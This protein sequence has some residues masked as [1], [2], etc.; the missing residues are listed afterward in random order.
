MTPSLR[1]LT[2]RVLRRIVNGFAID[3]CKV[4]QW[5][6]SLPDSWTGR[7]ATARLRA[8]DRYSLEGLQ[9]GAEGN[10][11]L[12][13]R[14][15]LPA[16]ARIALVRAD[17]LDFGCG[18]ASYRDLAV[19]FPAT[20]GWTYTGADVNRSIIDSCRK[21]MRENRFEVVPQD[22]TLPF[23]NG[24]FDVIFA[25]GVF[26]CVKQPEKLLA[27]FHRV[28]RGWVLLSRVPVRKHA[29]CGIYL[30]R[31]WHRWGR[32][33]HAIHVFNKEDLDRMC[34]SGGFDVVWRDHLFDRFQLSGEEEPALDQML[35]L[36]KREAA[37]D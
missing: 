30:Q 11:P 33:V 31:V 36:R 12:R 32:E 17:L 7:A 1:Q 2:L 19:C 18:D 23:A 27:E 34:A 26:H 25:S 14:G 15:E 21:R 5:P 10:L 9:P 13:A 29:G 20:S 24:S 28:T 35:L 8:R 4:S 3:Y 22:G 6:Q 16:L 37:H